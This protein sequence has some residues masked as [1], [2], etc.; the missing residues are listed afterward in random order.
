[1]LL[2][3]GTGPCL[4]KGQGSWASGESLAAVAQWLA[5]PQ[6]VPSPCKS[7]IKQD[8]GLRSGQ[9]APF[10]CDSS[11]TVGGWEVEEAGS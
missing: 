2:L 10:Q 7:F 3:L 5:P 1:M 4:P 11:A 6:A 9:G 8:Q